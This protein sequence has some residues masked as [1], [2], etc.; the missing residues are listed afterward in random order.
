MEVI[1][2]KFIFLFMVFA[3]ISTVIAVFENIVTY[4]MDL[5]GCSRRKSFSVNLVLLLLLSL[6]CVFGFNL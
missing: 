1:Y 2:G 6:P 4:G 3:A 5:T